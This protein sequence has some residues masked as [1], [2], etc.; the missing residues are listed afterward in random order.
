[1]GLGNA[2]TTEERP[3]HVIHSCRLSFDL[4]VADLRTRVGGGVLTAGDDGHDAARAGFNLLVDQRP[5]VIV[6]PGGLPWAGSGTRSR[7]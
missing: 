4:A 3:R 7:T 6:V 2:L 1:V 5:A